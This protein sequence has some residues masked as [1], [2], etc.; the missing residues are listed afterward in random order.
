[1]HINALQF[2]NALALIFFIQR[3]E[4]SLRSFHQSIIM[5]HYDYLFHILIKFNTRFYTKIIILQL[6]LRS[7]MQIKDRWFSIIK[8]YKFLF[9]IS[10]AN[11]R[12]TEILKLAA[13]DFSQT[14][15]IKPIPLYLDEVMSALEI[16]S[17][18]QNWK[19]DPQSRRLSRTFKF[20][21]FK[22]SFSFM[23]QSAIIS[24]QMKHYPSWK[25]QHKQ[26]NVELTSDQGVSMKD[27][28]LAFA[29]EQI[30]F[31]IKIGSVE[32]INDLRKLVPSLILQN[33]DSNY[34]QA[35]NYLQSMEKAVAQI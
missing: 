18:N 27:V 1:M 24:E 15:G 3:D 28:L 6:K 7:L 34:Q 35:E 8:M 29:M 23:N 32:T 33:W 11:P 14:R 4:Q 9:K 5:N 22:E 16:H 19:Y 13:S 26:V 10:Q 30:C 21:D 17:L 25:N 31:D 12:S 2:L 20:D